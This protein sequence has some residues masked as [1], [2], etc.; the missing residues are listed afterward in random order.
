MLAADWNAGRM[1]LRKTWVGEERPFFVSA[2]SGGDVA[3]ACVGREI[4]DVAVSAGCEHDG[5][6]GVLLDCSRDQVARD[7]SLGMTIDNYQ[8]EHFGLRKHLHG[9]GGNLT[10]ERLIT[11][12][13]KL[14][15]GL[16]ARVKRP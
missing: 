16:A 6:G 11:A 15:A 14:L 8:V 4:K 13:Q 7:D 12:E 5:V 9:A 1:D 3:T 10:R 2:I